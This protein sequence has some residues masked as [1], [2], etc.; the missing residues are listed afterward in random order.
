M[1][2]LKFFA[3]IGLVIYFG[4][5]LF[6]VLKDKTSQDAD[7]YFFAKRS[8]PFWALSITFIASWWGAGSAISTAD[9][10]YNDGMGAFWYYGSP[11]LLATFFMFL[12]AKSIRKTGSYTQG[13]IFKT[14][15][16]KTASLMLS[17]AIF[18]F[19]TITASSQMVG[20][21]DFFGTYLDMNY[22]LAIIVGTAIV[23]IYS[24]FGG[25][26]GVVITDIIQF[27][28]LFI[29][30]IIIFI[31]AYSKSGGISEIS[32]VADK[33]GKTDF[34]SFFGGLEK[35][36]VYI[37]TFG[38]AWMIQ[39]NVWQRISATRDVKD[40]KK[41]TM[42]SLCVYGPLYLMSVVTGMC[43]LVIYKEF[44]QGGIVINIIRDY[45]NPV[46]GAFIFIGITA[47]IMSTMDSL[48]NTG[49]LTLTLD[50]Y[51]E[52]INPNVSEKKLLNIS[53]GSTVIV[54][55]IA[56]FFSLKVRSILQV[57]WIA[58]DIITTGIFVPL[59]LGFFWR[60]GNSIGAI[61]SMISGGIFCTY[62]YFVSI[63]YNLP[64]PWEYGSTFQVIG[65]ISIS[66]FVYVLFSLLTEAEYEKADAFM[67]KAGTMR[68]TLSD[69]QVVG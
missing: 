33:L 13:E 62:H 48:I 20:I 30:S 24:L 50:I 4:V 42:M 28:I 11:A 21:G 6:V 5:L 56:L 9:L 35:Y 63:G 39:A 49:A 1:E 15:Y 64:I 66:L 69:S 19:M 58:S 68:N 45:L 51:K 34:T 61:A 46:L 7:D 22:E 38:A 41:M 12:M 54:T 55:I 32:M 52:K 2:H 23:F 14:R 18:L 40:S 37:I 10:A 43:G 67:E 8:L 31:V 65:G 25:F 60:R 47:A 53:K 3:I 36:Y 29:S 57:S 27:I 59:V 17:I 16:N 44:P 26:R